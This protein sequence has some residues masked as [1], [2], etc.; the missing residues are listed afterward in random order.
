MQLN[1]LEMKMPKILESLAQ[2]AVK[3]R[4]YKEFD[5]LGRLIAEHLLNS[6]DPA[7]RLYAGIVLA[8]ASAASSDTIE[9]VAPI[10]IAE[11]IR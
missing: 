1:A 8:Q 7:T 2:D 4:Q 9:I 5:A 3:L 11:S 6:D 10:A